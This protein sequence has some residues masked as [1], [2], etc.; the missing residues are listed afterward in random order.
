MPKRVVT[1]TYSDANW[2]QILARWGTEAAYKKWVK[3]R[4]LAES[5]PG[6]Y[7]STYTER[8]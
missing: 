7:H 2:K 6:V 5:K 1:L 3:A 4:T 8:M